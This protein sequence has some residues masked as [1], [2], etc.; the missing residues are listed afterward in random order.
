[1]QKPKITDY[2]QGEEAKIQQNIGDFLTLKGWYVRNTH[3]NMYSNGW[4]DM[5][6][7]HQKFGARWIEVKKPT[8]YSFTPAQLQQFPLFCAHGA[9][10]WIMTAATEEQYQCLFKRCNWAH[11]LNLLCAGG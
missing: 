6:V 11:Y 10:I 7:V 2:Q 4:P 8:G 3:G 9:G 1:M 5:Y